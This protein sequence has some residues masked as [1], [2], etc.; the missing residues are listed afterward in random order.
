MDFSIKN[1]G[2]SEKR[3]K[4]LERQKKK[5][6]NNYTREE[7]QIEINQCR[8]KI[9]QVGLGDGIEMQR[10]WQI[11]DKYIENGDAISGFVKIPG[12]KRVFVYLFPK[13]KRHKISATLQY[14]EN[15]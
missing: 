8:E 13:S 9:E 5:N 14:N 11:M 4:H 1:S 7:R 3:L 2:K 12:T 15:V 10:I 6:E